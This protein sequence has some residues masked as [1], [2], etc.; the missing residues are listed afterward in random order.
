MKSMNKN[1]MAVAL[2]AGTA[3]LSVT[4]T[5]FAMTDAECNTAWTTADA[6]KDGV[7]TAEEGSRYHAAIRVGDKT[8]VDGKLSQADFLAHCKAG[9]FS[10]RANDAGA[11]LKGANSFTESQAT[12]RATAHGL[13]QVTGLKKDADGIWRGTAQKDGKPVKVGVDFKGNVV[14]E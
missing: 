8:I 5:A 9:L 10:V 4:T 1:L 3:A 11:P 7:L 14:A 13:S 6:N 12:D 2:L